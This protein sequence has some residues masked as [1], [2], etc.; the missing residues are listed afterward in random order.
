MTKRQQLEQLIL[1]LERSRAPNKERIEAAKAAI[2]FMNSW[3]DLSM[4][5]GHI[6]RIGAYESY[7]FSNFNEYALSELGLGTVTVA[8]KDCIL[9]EKRGIFRWRT[10]LDVRQLPD[11]NWCWCASTS[12]YRLG[13]PPKPCIRWSKTHVERARQLNDTLLERVGGATV[14]IETLLQGG[15]ELSQL[16]AIHQW[17]HFTDDET[18]AFIG[19]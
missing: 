19:G 2:A 15:L 3:V 4:Q 14:S 5:L 13:G 8:H 18:T 6:R 7:G 12:V 9:L 1:L 17:L 10:I 16:T 11:S